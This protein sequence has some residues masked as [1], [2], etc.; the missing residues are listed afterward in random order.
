[1]IAGFGTCR[2]V[3]TSRQQCTGV[4]QHASVKARGVRDCENSSSVSRTTGGGNLST[5][6][7]TLCLP[8]SAHD[9]TPRYLTH[10]CTPLP[11]YRVR[12]HIRTIKM[13]DLPNTNMSDRPNLDPSGQRLPAAKD[14]QR[15]V[16][17]QTC[18]AFPESTPR[19][20]RLKHQLGLDAVLSRIRGSVNPC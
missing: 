14:Y 7:C 13:L 9:C 1:M 3:Y 2:A 6:L 20:R 4:Y 8:C 18:P 10:A 16:S 11:T 17:I 12:G 19:S 15:R 5:N